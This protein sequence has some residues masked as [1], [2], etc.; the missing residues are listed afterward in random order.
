[1]TDDAGVEPGRAHWLLPAFSRDALRALDDPN[2]TAEERER[3]MD[4]YLEG[5]AYDVL[6]G[7][8]RPLRMLFGL[9]RSS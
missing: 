4:E 7:E 8:T 5:V 9:R 6:H 1:M 3:I 2:L